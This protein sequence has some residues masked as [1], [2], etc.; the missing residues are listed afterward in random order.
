MTPRADAPDWRLAPV[1]VGD[2]VVRVAS[3]AGVR[4]HGASD[5]PDAM[6]AQALDRLLSVHAGHR[7]HVVVLG[8]GNGM[9]AAVAAAHGASVA[10]F[11][12]YAPHA[13]ATRRTLDAAGQRTDGAQDG[14]IDD[15]RAWHAQVAVGHLGDGAAA[16]V[17]IRLPTDRASAQL[18][19]AESVR[20]LAP[21]GV[22]LL[23][24][25]NDEGAKPAARHL[26]ERFSDVRVDAQHSGCR[27]LVARGIVRTTPPSVD[28]ATR[29]LDLDAVRE[30][31]VSLAGEATTL[32]TR[33]G[34][35]SWEHLDEATAI[36]SE[37]LR[38]QAI[39]S[40]GQSVLDLGCG[41]GALAV[42]AGR[43]NGDA[44]VLAVD[45]DSEAVRCTA[46][47]AARA[48]LRQV[49]AQ[50]HDV[51][52]GVGDVAVDRVVSNPPFHLGKGT[53]LT[54]PRAFIA[55]AHAALVPGGEALFVANRTLPYEALIEARFGTVRTV[56][57]GRRFKVLAGT[58]RA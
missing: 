26:A 51:V 52:D 58:R 28:D 54:L 13:E 3:R 32:C 27:L 34:V 31:H 20:L 18:L 44:W 43:L 50:A 12:R 7:P 6:L 11:D 49:Q 19:V 45:A 47:T 57:D 41:A 2:R 46:L 17:L 53:D 24:G 22:C 37:I 23:A 30:L 10:A 16:C 38:A 9:V 48:G 5:V 33:P 8:S 25:A 36:L 39:I 4:G 21:D 35:F 42:V 29:W 56:H 55:A 14:H 15:R 1:S 40:P